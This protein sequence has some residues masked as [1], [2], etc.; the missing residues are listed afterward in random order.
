[1]NE[2]AVVVE[3]SIKDKI[4]KALNRSLLVLRSIQMAGKQKFQNQSKIELKNQDSNKT[5]PGLNCAGVCN[6]QATTAGAGWYLVGTDR[7]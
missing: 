1:M 6:P 4:Q 3:K 7:Y 2:Q 5:R